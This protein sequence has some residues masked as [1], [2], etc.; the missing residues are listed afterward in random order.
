MY[1][2]APKG[3]RLQR[4]F[5]GVEATKESGVSWWSLELRQWRKDPNDFPCSTICAEV[6][7]LSA[8]RKHLKKHPELNGRAV[9]VSGFIGYN[10]YANRE[11]Y[12]A[13]MAQ[14]KRLKKRLAIRKQQRESINA[15]NTAS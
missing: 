14:K 7:T 1:F 4:Y 2:E 12:E 11:D 3:K 10:V 8:F 9:L 6:K 15:D 5:V 13:D